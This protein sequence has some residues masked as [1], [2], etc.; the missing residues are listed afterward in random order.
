MKEADQSKYKFASL[1]FAHGI[2][3]F[4]NK[5]IIFTRIKTKVVVYKL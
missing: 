4:I 1:I 5:T 3:S 2:K